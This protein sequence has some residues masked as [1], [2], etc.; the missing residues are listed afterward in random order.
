LTGSASRRC[1]VCERHAS[2][3]AQSAQPG[4]CNNVESGSRRSLKGRLGG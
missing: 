2:P 3:P 4:P 1:S